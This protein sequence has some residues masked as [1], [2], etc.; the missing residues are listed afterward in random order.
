M[1]DVQPIPEGFHTI[2][3]H[4]VVE[5]AAAFGGGHP[6]EEEGEKASTES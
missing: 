1:S 6:G 2:T 5:G 3:P 4:I